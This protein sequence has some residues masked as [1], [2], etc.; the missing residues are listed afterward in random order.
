MAD[1]EEAFTSLVHK[2][3]EQLYWHIRGIVLSHEDADDILQDVFVK[4]WK[5]LPFFRGDSSEFTWLWRIATNESLNFLLRKKLR[6]VFVR[7]DEAAGISSDPYFNGDEAE[8]KFQT[9]L[10]HLPAKQLS[11]FCMRYYE[12]LTYEQISDI[13]GTSVG[14]LKASYH[15]AREKINQELNLSSEKTSKSQI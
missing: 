14:A 13:T 4:A 15:I 12:D 5:A 1:R 6:S 11:V 9:A 7:I 10:S 2:Y 8:A 3:S